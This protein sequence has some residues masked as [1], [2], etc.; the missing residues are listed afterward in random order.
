MGDPDGGTLFPW[1]NLGLE[2]FGQRK[3]EIKRGPSW[4]GPHS[5]TCCAPTKPKGEQIKGGGTGREKS[6]ARSNSAGRVGAGTATRSSRG[7]PTQ[8]GEGVP[9]KETSPDFSERK[10]PPREP[11]LCPSS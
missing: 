10:P 7:S 1:G 5:S 3:E 9:G 11:C 2:Q 4:A 8:Q 6:G